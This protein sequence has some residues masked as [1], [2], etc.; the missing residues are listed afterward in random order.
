MPAN[1]TDE[2]RALLGG[3]CEKRHP[4]TTT[5]D[6][7]RGR[8]GRS[9]RLLLETEGAGWLHCKRGGGREREG[10]GT[11]GATRK[12]HRLVY[13]HA[14]REGR[15]GDGGR[16]EGS[17]RDVVKLEELGLECLVCDDEGDEKEEEE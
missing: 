17:Q 6:G 11:G 5:T 3:K 14:P 15:G 4:T 13:R 2:E 16:V 12:S 7:E 1:K 9:P 10:G 8:R